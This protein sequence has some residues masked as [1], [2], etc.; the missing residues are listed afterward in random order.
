MSTKCLGV[1]VSL[2]FLAALAVGFP[3]SLWAQSPDSDDSS[4]PTPIKN[5]VVIFKENV[6]F[7][8]YFGT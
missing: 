2:L 8:H 6:S 7:D 1:F 5:V 3:A 4:T